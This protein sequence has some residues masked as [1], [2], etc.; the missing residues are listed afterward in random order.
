MSKREHRKRSAPEYEHH[1]PERREVLEFLRTVNKPRNLKHIAAALGVDSTAR[2]AA[3]KKRLNA[4]VRDGEII[5]NRKEGFGLT[6]KMDL[7]VG[8]VIGHTDGYGFLRPDHGPPDLFLSAREMQVLMHGDRVAVRI[9]G[10][11]RRNQPEGAVVEILE[12]ANR[13]VVGRYFREGQLGFVA[14][15]NKRLHQDVLI[16]AGDEGKAKSGQYV[17][18]DI[19]RY[20][21]RHTQPVGKITEILRQDT[22]VEMA[23]EI[24]IRAHDIPWEWPEEIELELAAIGS[25]KI[26]AKDRNDLRELPFVTI[27]G[28]DARDF[29]DAVC[30]AKTAIGWKLYVAIAD[31]T[32]YVPVGGALDREAANRG[33]SVYFPQRVVPMLPEL[34]SNDLCSLKPEVDRP[35]LV[36]EISID[37]RGMVKE[38]RFTRALIHSRRRMTYTEMAAAVVTK[39]AGLRQALGP[40]IEHLDKLYQL[41]RLLHGARMKR[42]ILEFGATETRMEFDNKGRIRQISPLIRNDAHRLIEEFMLTANVAAAELL[43]KQELPSLYRNHEPPNPEKLA[44]LREFLAGFG[45]E[46]GGGD[47][48]DVE[49]YKKVLEAVSDK[50]HAHLVETVLLRSMNLAVYEAVNK[51]H[52]GLAFARYTHFTSPIRRYP[53]LLVHRAISH[54]IKGTPFHYSLPDMHNL[55]A[56]CSR[57]ERR[58]DDATRDVAQHL[59]CEFMEDRIGEV[60]N[61]T[62]SGVTAFGLFVEL[63]DVLV[64]GLVHVTALPNDYYHFDATTRSLRG[65]RSGHRFHLADRVRVSVS[66]VDI[67][68]KKIDLELVDGRK[69]RK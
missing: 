57:T 56:H 17:V 15:D 49:D 2:Q 20:P 62:V 36:C 63:D 45:L 67:D 4:M 37:R 64:E 3:L 42:G 1:I 43:E 10:I 13:K 53:D 58:A 46:L 29:D 51:G 32:A 50:D 26:G 21:D 34:L 48:P 18:A 54:A 19:T 6:E 40:L 60:F 68:E 28:E 61:G 5:K 38:S 22:Y 41:F 8:E 39:D 69:S 23:T 44:D 59:K 11:G 47:K 66:R 33:T 25:K 65:E 9:S 16:P 12:R 35:C 27:D 52:F 31:V 24:A 55:G 7:I 14:P 30:C